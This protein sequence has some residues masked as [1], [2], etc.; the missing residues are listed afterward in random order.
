MLSVSKHA[1]SQAD[2][3]ES[4][5]LLVPRLCL[6]TQGACDSAAARAAA[7]RA[8]LAGR[9]RAEP[10]YEESRLAIE[11]LQQDVDL[12]FTPT[13][14]VPLAACPP[15]RPE[16]TDSKL[17]VVHQNPDLGVFRIEVSADR[18]SS[19]QRGEQTRG[20]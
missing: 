4:W 17:S 10:G 12:I 8:C 20:L 3:P 19:I 13:V 16:S 11:K 2:L 7:G 14:C 18:R 5:A 6:G 15:V 1:H 9:T